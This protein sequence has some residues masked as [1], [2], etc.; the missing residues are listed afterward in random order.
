MK[1]I[2]QCISE[3]KQFCEN[4]GIPEINVVHD[5]DGA[6]VINEGGETSIKE[7]YVEE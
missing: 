1:T 3:A 4:I 2:E 5:K 6:Y 7:I